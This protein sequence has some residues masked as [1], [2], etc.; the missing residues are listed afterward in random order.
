MNNNNYNAA[1]ELL[2]NKP[3]EVL[4]KTAFVDDYESIKYSQL[5]KKV[6]KFFI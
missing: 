6:Q 1:Y 3:E 4:N 2:A 5:I